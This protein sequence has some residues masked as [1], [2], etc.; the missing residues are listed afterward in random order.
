MWTCIFSSRQIY[1][2][3]PSKSKKYYA[4]NCINV[5]SPKRKIMTHKHT[6]IRVK[7]RTSLIRLV[8]KPGKRLKVGEFVNKTDVFE[9]TKIKLKEK[10][11]DN[12][13][14]F[15]RTNIIIYSLLF[16]LCSYMT[17]KFGA[18]TCRYFNPSTFSSSLRT[19][20]PHQNLATNWRKVIP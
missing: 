18:N 4:E 5:G 19:C 6:Y 8:L 7:I 9:Y 14:I 2:K 16:K 10:K 3:P 15:Q 1:L 12:E 13:K 20:Y 11:S 17:Q